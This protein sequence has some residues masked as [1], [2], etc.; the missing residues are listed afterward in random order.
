MSGDMQ[1]VDMLEGVQRP[2]VARLQAEVAALKARLAAVEAETVEIRAAARD[3]LNDL[4][5]PWEAF[6]DRYYTTCGVAAADRLLR[7]L[8][9]DAA[10]EDAE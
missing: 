6:G 5:G 2:Q 3:V 9:P 8:L 7:A 10:R 1:V 4:R